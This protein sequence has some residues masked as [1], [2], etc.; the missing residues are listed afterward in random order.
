[1]LQGD[2]DHLARDVQRVIG[3]L[4]GV[5]AAVYRN[6]A[7]GALP[8][9][10]FVVTSAMEQRPL[11]DSRVTLTSE[12]DALGVPRAQLDWRLTESD[13]QSLRRSLDILGAE[14][15][16]AGLGRLK[17]TLGEHA[18]DWLLQDGGHHMGATRMHTEPKQ[19]V[20]DADCKV[21]GM[22]NLFVAGSSI[23]PTSGHANPTLTLVA[24]AVRLADHLKRIM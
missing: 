4:D 11:A 17:V 2:F 5:T 10:K 18:R 6:W 8:V 24:L 1:M 3:D 9:E 14:F 16:R 7:Y 22:S 15:G 12:R 20:V 19:G 23:F 13:V 21:H